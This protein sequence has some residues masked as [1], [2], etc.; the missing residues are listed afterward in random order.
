M[1]TPKSGFT[2]VDGRFSSMQ[3][4]KFK[5]SRE[6]KTRWRSDM[7]MFALDLMR[8]RIVEG[9]KYLCGRKAGYL[10]GCSDWNYAKGSKQVGAFLWLGPRDETKVAT[11]DEVGEPLTEQ[12]RDL[13]VGQV[14]EKAA[15]EGEDMATG[16][17]ER[18][19]Q[20][21]SFD[22]APGEFATLD[23]D[24]EMKSKVPVHNLQL[25]LGSALIKDLRRDIPQI[26]KYEVV[27]LKHRK[28]TI[29][30]QLRLWKLQG[31]LA[32]HK[33]ADE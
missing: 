18:P 7:D 20:E 32:E 8:R 31:Y 12:E 5:A 14:E 28:T 27:A 21:S 19:V 11:S 25:L 13:A 26:F 30:V 9:L 22:I 2:Y 29:D 4:K 33:Q 23:R 3:A 15:C 16:Q 24:K 10:Q 6:M 17:Q 1:S